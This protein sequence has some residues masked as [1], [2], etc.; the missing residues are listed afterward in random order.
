MKLVVVQYWRCFRGCSIGLQIKNKSKG[1]TL[2][3]AKILA[4]LSGHVAQVGCQMFT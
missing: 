4:R 1:R 3:L 2:G